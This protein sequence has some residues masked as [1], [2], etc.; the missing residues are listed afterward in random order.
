MRSVSIPPAHR[1]AA[2]AERYGYVNRVVPDDDELLAPLTLREPGSN[3]SGCA[4]RDGWRS[5][6]S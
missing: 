5:D 2:L 3:T 6:R 1:D 4:G